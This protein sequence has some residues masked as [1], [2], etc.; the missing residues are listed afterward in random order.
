MKRGE[1]HRKQDVVS[2]DQALLA[3]PTPDQLTN[4]CEYRK[5]FQHKFNE[6]I[7][8]NKTKNFDHL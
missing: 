1:R 3:K 6:E 2:E 7:I 8:G 5:K 4:A